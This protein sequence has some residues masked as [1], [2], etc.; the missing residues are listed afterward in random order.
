MQDSSPK[1]I[2]ESLYTS[3]HLKMDDVIPVLYRNETGNTDFEVLVFAKNYVSMINSI[4]P[5]YYAWYT[6]KSQSSVKFN[7]PAEISVGA[8]YRGD[9]GQVNTA[10]PFKASL[11]S[12]W[13]IT[14]P[15]ANDTPVLEECKLK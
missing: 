6:L 15:Y 14:Q 8:E 4:Q 2:T 9:G 1:K 13:E 3:R 12:T 11:G 5:Y 10:G 7:F